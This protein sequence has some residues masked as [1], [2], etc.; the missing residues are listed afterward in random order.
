MTAEQL[1]QQR[2]TYNQKLIETDSFFKS[3]G[4]L[5]A[6]AYADGAISKKNKEL[7]GLAISVVTRCNE[8]VLYHLETSIKAEATKEELIEAIKIGVIGGGS[9]TYPNARFAI[10][11]IEELLNDK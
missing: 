11:M 3:F 1:K 8:C 7:I 6:N 9:I 2:M 4:E 5:D 10:K